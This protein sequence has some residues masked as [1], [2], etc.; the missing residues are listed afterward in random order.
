MKG[1]FKRKRDK[2]WQMNYYI[3]GRRVYE[4]SGTTEKRLAK[5][6]LAKRRAD[7][8]EGRHLSKKLTCNISFSALCD[9]YWD[10]RGY[11]LKTKG[12]EGMVK[13]LKAYFKNTPAKAI[14]SSRV[15]SYLVTH[16]DKRGLAVSTRNRHLALIRTIFNWGMKEKEEAHLPPLVSH[17]PCTDVEVFNE[18]HLRRNRYLDAS[19]VQALLDASNDAFRPFLHMCFAHWNATR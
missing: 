3:N 1:L 16:I 14:T 10:K 5:S 4:S 9:R 6:I 13:A 8:A 17:N 11:K 15:E 7:V 19:E 18:E 2:Y 12:L